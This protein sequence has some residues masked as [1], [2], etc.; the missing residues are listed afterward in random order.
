MWKG[1]SALILRDLM[2]LPNKISSKPLHPKCYPAFLV[3]IHNKYP[4]CQR[5]ETVSITKDEQMA[6]V[7]YLVINYIR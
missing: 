5:K 3:I 7:S 4:F 2:A 6:I 1:T